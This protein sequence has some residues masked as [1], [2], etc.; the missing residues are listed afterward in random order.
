MGSQTLTDWARAWWPAF[1]GGAAWRARGGRVAAPRW[2]GGYFRNDADHRDFVAIGTAAGVA[3]AFAAPIGGLLFTIEE[4]ASFYSTSIFWRGFLATG[5]GVLTLHALVEAAEHPS[6]FWAARFG[7]YRDFGLYADSLA[8][9]GSR[10]FYYVWDV[11]IFC[12]MGCIGGGAGAAFVHLNVR[13]TAWRH[14]HIPAAKRWTRVAEAAGLAA[15]T[16]ALWFLVAYTSPCA[17]LPPPDDLKF[18]EASEDADEAL[19]GG[20][21][22]A[23]AGPHHYP[24]LWCE[25]GSYAVHGQLFFA[26]LSQALRLV[27]HLGEP[28]PEARLDAYGLHPLSLALL[29]ILGFG[30][31]VLTNGVGASTG[32][33]VP[34]LAVG[35]AGGRLVGQAVRAALRASGSTLPISM[36]AYAVVGA[37][38]FMGGATRMTLTATVMVMETTGAL[39]LIVPLIATVF[40]AKVVGDLFGAGVDDTHVKIRGAPVL[41]EPGL[42]ARQKMVADKLTVGEL[43]AAPVV[44]LPPVVPVARLLAVLQSCNHQAFP[45]SPDAEDDWGGGAGHGGGG[46]G[47]DRT[48]PQAGRPAGGGGGAPPS[49]TAPPGLGR[50][51]VHGLILRDVLLRLLETGLGRVPAGADPPAEPAIPPTQAGREAVLAALER[52]PVKLR[53]GPALA[54]AAARLAGCTES[55]DLRPFMQRHPFVIP[56]DASLARAYRLFRTLG[57]RHML[58]TP[59]CPPAVGLVTRKDLCEA[60]ARLALGAKAVAGLATVT[61]RLV[62]PGPLPFI[63]YE[64]YGKIE[65]GGAA[66]WGLA[67]AGGGGGGGAVGGAG[68]GGGGGAAG[69]ASSSG[70]SPSLARAGSGGLSGRRRAARGSPG[71]PGGGGGG[72]TVGGGGGGSM[73]M[74]PLLAPPALPAAAAEGSGDGEGGSGGGGGGP[75]ERRQQV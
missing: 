47:L 28:L 56:A 6:T 25:A 65:D 44:V 34:A 22:T 19:Y 45:V 74:S 42:T 5:A 61:D 41:D 50:F 75:T 73:E 16:A 7:R 46:G 66:G 23:A 60:N 52:R 14:A 53:P 9:Y 59:A 57:L 55:V 11:P 26:P 43:A 63:P 33:F 58:V 69:F 29:A 37:A 36:P 20:G 72:L 68:G 4:G 71:G 12:A 8:F 32:M 3:T 49:P 38:G 15:V 39:Q 51:A 70:V 13:V 24:R 21:G 54:S 17:P 1:L 2:A 62:R 27:V 18:L 48:P 40:C 67:G 64:P 30:G 10:M 31:M 35:A